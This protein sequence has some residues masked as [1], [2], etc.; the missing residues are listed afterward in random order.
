MQTHREAGTLDT[1]LAWEVPISKCFHLQT[2]S[3][4]G[5]VDTVR[6]L[7]DEADVDVNRTNKKSGFTALL[8]A[9]IAKKIDCVRVLLAVPGIDL[10]IKDRKGT[11]ALGRAQPKVIKNL[12]IEAGALEAVTVSASVEVGADSGEGDL[13]L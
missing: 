7:I 2:A 4:N 3:T 1:V 6:L 12:L 13:T 11:T 8:S 10:E 5:H 9:V